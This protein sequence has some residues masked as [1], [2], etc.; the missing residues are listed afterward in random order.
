MAD[1]LGFRNPDEFKLLWVLDFPLFEYARMKMAEQV[2]GWPGTI[3]LRR[4]NQT[5]S[6]S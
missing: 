6:P 5:I 3:R 1:R 2:D 4:P